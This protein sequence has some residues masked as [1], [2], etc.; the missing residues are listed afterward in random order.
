MDGI[1][2]RSPLAPWLDLFELEMVRFSSKLVQGLNQSLFL[3]S[4]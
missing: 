3:Q 1:L 2:A 4:C